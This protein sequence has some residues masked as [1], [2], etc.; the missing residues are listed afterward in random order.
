[1]C[2]KLWVEF[3]ES[4]LVILWKLNG[5]GTNLVASNNQNILNIMIEY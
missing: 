3:H 1:M 5:L 4:L 2:V